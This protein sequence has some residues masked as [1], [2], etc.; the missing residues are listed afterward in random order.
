MKIFDL[1]IGL[2]L[3]MVGFSVYCIPYMIFI[4]FFVYAL[5][6]MIEASK[7]MKKLLYRFIF[8]VLFWITVI[9]F[10]IPILL[11]IDWCGGK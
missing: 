2:S 9:A 10:A 11:F 4:R 5:D 1:F 7:G 8:L 6:D 3:F